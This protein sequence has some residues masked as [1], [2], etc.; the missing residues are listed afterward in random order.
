MRTGVRK[1]RKK[2]VMVEA[3]RYDGT[4]NEELEDFAE[5]SIVFRDIMSDNMTVYI[6]TLEGEMKVSK[7]DYVIKGVKGEFYPCKP[8]IFDK[9]YEEVE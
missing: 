1:F 4:N 9:S 7:G 2:P 8:D 6:D 5:S 3:L